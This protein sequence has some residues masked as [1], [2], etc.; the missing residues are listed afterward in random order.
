MKQEP[1][2][3]LTTTVEIIMSIGNVHPDKKWD[4]NYF[5]TKLLY[6]TMIM[7]IFLIKMDLLGKNKLTDVQNHKDYLLIKWD[8]EY[9]NNKLRS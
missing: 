5:K 9:Y 4:R 1:N 6:L 3:L 2:K 7:N 8:F